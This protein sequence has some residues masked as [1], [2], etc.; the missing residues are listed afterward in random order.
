MWRPTALIF[1]F[2]VVLILVARAPEFLSVEG[3]RGPLSCSEDRIATFGWTHATRAHAELAAILRWK[4]E[5]AE[6]GAAY[7]EWHHARARHLTCRRIGGKN[8][9]FQCR[10]SGTPCKLGGG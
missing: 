9:Q 4:K 5:S 8:G 10:I 6:Q 2:P 7:S 3:T 1:L